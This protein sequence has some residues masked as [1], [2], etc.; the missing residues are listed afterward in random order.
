MEIS[1]LHDQPD[2]VALLALNNANSRETS[3]L[4]RELFDQLVGDP[5]RARYVLALGL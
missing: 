4:T 2:R 1:D 3:L 5:A